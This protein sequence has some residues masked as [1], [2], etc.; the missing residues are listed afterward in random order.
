M[1]GTIGLILHPF[2]PQTKSNQN[3]TNKANRFTVFQNGNWQ[4]YSKIYLEIQKKNKNNWDNLEGK[5]R[6]E[7]LALM[8]IDVCYKGNTESVAEE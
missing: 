5:E 7:R 1:A 6:V 8:H 2:P 4:P 3:R